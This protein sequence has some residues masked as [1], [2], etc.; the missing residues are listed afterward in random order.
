MSTS[1]EKISNLSTD[2]VN[3]PRCDIEFLMLASQ[4]S[5]RINEK[6]T[7]PRIKKY[8]VMLKNQRKRLCL[9]KYHLSQRWRKI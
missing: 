2:I 6:N 9:G 4:A 3:S 5:Y 1:K 8:E 7:I